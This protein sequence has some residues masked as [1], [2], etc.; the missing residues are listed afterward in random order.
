MIQLLHKLN[1]LGM[2]NISFKVILG[3]AKGNGEYLM[4]DRNYVF[5]VTGKSL[6]VINNGHI[7]IGHVT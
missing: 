1:C 5:V 6:K 2:G 3:C 4:A 7:C